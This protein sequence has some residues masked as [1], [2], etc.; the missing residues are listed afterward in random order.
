MEDMAAKDTGIPDSR[1]IPATHV[2][3][4][5]VSETFTDFKDQPHT[6]WESQLD[7][8]ITSSVTLNRNTPNEDYADE[9]NSIYLIN[10]ADVFCGK[11][12]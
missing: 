1:C 4:Q 3:F 2:V 12:R 11:Y 9:R 7:T 10:Q 6:V 5:C 8:T